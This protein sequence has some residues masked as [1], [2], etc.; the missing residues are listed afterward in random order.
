[1]RFDLTPLGEDQRTQVA[2]LAEARECIKHLGLTA[3]KDAVLKVDQRKE[4][5]MTVCDVRI[6]RVRRK[7]RRTSFYL[8]GRFDADWR[9]AFRRELY[10]F[11]IPVEARGADYEDGVSIN[12]DAIL[13]LRGWG[14]RITV[15]S[16]ISDVEFGVL[17]SSLALAINKANQRTNRLHAGARLRTNHRRL[18]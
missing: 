7:A 3:L 6:G 15:H 17:Q 14:L 12:I 9:D 8:V 2:D 10:D 11:T 4:I 16:S 13:G 1:M 18:Q 5:D